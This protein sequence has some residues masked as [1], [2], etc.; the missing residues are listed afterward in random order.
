MLKSTEQIQGKSIAD[1]NIAQTDITLNA[2]EKLNI[3]YIKKKQNIKNRWYHIIK[4]TLVLLFII[5]NYTNVTNAIGPN[6]SQ[7]IM[8]PKNFHYNPVPD[9]LKNVSPITSLSTK[10]IWQLIKHD[11]N[12]KTLENPVLLHN[13]HLN[14]LYRFLMSYNDISI[15]RFNK[16][17]QKI[18]C[19]MTLQELIKHLMKTKWYNEFLKLITDKPVYGYSE[20]LVLRI[21]ISIHTAA[22][23]FQIPFPTLFCLIFQESKFDFTAQSFSGAIGLGQLTTIAIK[24]VDKLR[25][26]KSYEEKIIGASIHLRNVY[27]DPVVKEILNKLGFN[28]KF[29]KLG[30][31]PKVIKKN[32]L[33]SNYII[34]DVGAILVKNGYPYGNDY[35]LVKSKIK[36][37]L[38]GAILRG[39]YTQMRPILTDVTDKYFGFKYGNV[40]NVETNI[41][42][43]AMILRHYIMY[44][45][46]LDGK[47][48]SLTPSLRTIIAITAYNQGERP[49]LLFLK[50]L[51]KDHPEIDI[52]TVVPDDLAPLFTK[53]AISKALKK[54]SGRTLEV[55]KHVREMRD[56]SE[57]NVKRPWEK[58]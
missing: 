55:Y 47:R 5:F 40:L 31:F 3:S 41:L 6:Q 25:K 43:S 16:S 9:S 17:V 49:V 35:K 18:P 58:K 2:T 14:E 27:K 33:L 24:Q 57:K 44:P 22:Y 50:Q 32:R 34:K 15:K 42:V 1:K 48:L 37:I 30:E 23:F 39:K 21:V 12:I 4:I 20:D 19:Q 28:P 54:S 52:E 45:W 51:L 29:P 46:K 53:K 10:E 26:K 56:C 11:Y 13:K 8:L 36:K 38:R 7:N